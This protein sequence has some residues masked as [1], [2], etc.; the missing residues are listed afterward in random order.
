MIQAPSFVCYIT[1]VR[2]TRKPAICMQLNNSRPAPPATPPPRS[3]SR[4]CSLIF[5]FQAKTVPPKQSSIRELTIHRDLFD[6]VLLCGKCAWRSP[7]GENLCGGWPLRSSCSAVAGRCERSSVRFQSFVVCFLATSMMSG[8]SRRWS[9]A[10]GA[11][12]GPAPKWRQRVSFAPI[13]LLQGTEFAVMAL[14]TRVPDQLAV[15]AVQEAAGC[16]G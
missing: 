16:G 6:E 4:K 8:G 11:Q 1:V 5:S 9:L 3:V 15:R 2:R 14:T 12:L 13:R 7:G 10:H